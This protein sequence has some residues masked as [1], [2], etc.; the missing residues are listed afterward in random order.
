[1]PM[2]SG[3]DKSASFLCCMPTHAGFPFITYISP[4][5]AKSVVHVPYGGI[6]NSFF[7]CHIRNVLVIGR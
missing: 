7:F 1:M 2:L 4:L 6:Y 5:S 3:K